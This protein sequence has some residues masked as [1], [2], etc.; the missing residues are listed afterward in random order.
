ML[1]C[2]ALSIAAPVAAQEEGIGSIQ[3]KPGVC[4]AGKSQPVALGALIVAPDAFNGKC[5]RVM[6]VSAGT[7]LYDS[8]V[9]YEL[10]MAGQA[11]APVARIGLYGDPALLDALPQDPTPT[12]IVGQVALCGGRPFVAGYCHYV[13]DGVIL[14]ASEAGPPNHNVD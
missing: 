4:T 14:I 9:E 1:A 3:L 6:G 2:L 7:V 8:Q 12:E 10:S 13:A 11:A 5:V